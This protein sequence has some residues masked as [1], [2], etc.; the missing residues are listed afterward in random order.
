MATWRALHKSISTS[1]KILRLFAEHGQDAEFAVLLYTWLM[2]HVDA[3][4]RTDA[5]PHIVRCR[6]VPT[7]EHRTVSDVRIALDYLESVN[8]IIRY[9]ADGKDV[10]EIVGFE[11]KQ[12]YLLT[13]ERAH[14]QCSE[15][16]ENPDALTASSTKCKHDANIMSTSG[17]HHVSLQDRKTEQKKTEEIKD[18]CSVASPKT[19]ASDDLVVE[20]REFYR[21]HHPDPQ[22]PNRPGKFLSDK[23]IDKAIRGALRDGMDPEAFKRTCAKARLNVAIYDLVNGVKGGA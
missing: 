3:W 18:R 9:S 13:R 6:V 4:G 16:P 23:G 14:S 5:N 15:Y 8:L 11:A 1:E 10:L 7:F 21:K 12:G 22:V 17:K 19:P 20:L 2:A